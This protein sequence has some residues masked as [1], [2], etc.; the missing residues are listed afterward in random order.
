MVLVRVGDDDSDQ[1]LLRLLDKAEIGHDEIDAGQ[2][3]ACKGH[4]EIDHQPLARVCGP[5]AV[6]GAIH[7]DLAQAAER[8]EHE[9]AVVRHL[10]SALPRLRSRKAAGGGR[11]IE[12]RELRSA[13]S[14]LS[15]PRSERMSRRPPASIPSKTPSRRPPP[16]S[17]ATRW[18]RPWTRSS[19]AARIRSNASSL[20]P[21][22]ERLVEPLGRDA[23]TTRP[24][25]PLA[26][27]RPSDKRSRSQ[28]P[29]AHARN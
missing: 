26:R 24:R 8:G 2:V 29:P 12:A 16:L 25:R 9:L 4:A 7:A 6:K 3:L 22:D 21:G 20:A 5:V 28:G 13:A 27:W 11:P 18:P 17:I 14:M 23:R 15:S 10:G 19:Q 1:I